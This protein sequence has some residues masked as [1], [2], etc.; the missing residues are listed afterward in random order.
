M[1][2]CLPASP[3]R[4]YLQQQLTRQVLSGGGAG[5]RAASFEVLARLLHAAQCAQAGLVELAA[6]EMGKPLTTSERTCA[7]AAAANW[8]RL[9]D[10]VF[11]LLAAVRMEELFLGAME[12]EHLSLL[13][14]QVGILLVQATR[15]ATADA[16]GGA[17]GACLRQL[18]LLA[19]LDL[20]LISPHLDTLWPLHLWA[21]SSTPSCRAEIGTHC[22]SLV[23][24]F[25]ATRVLPVL[26]VSAFNS[27]CASA[28]GERRSFAH[29]RH[30]SELSVTAL[31]VWAYPSVSSALETAAASVPPP[32]ACLCH[33]AT[34]MPLCLNVVCSDAGSS[35]RDV[36]PRGD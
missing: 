13:A 31:T 33:V 7:A 16:Q 32:Q 23:A 27:L 8:A 12:A 26:L 20:G 14:E 11:S 4:S 21:A 1:E 3:N 17:A 5:A 35:S 22:A 34:I 6:P 30:C 24:S 19:E 10:T 15:L 29:M 18:S 28:A 25:A 9:T 2:A 36:C